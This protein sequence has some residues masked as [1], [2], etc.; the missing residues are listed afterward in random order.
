[1]STTTITHRDT[2]TVVQTAP[3]SLVTVN[4]GRVGPRGPAGIQ[5]PPGEVGAPGESGDAGP[6]GDP[7]PPGADGRTILSGS[8]APSSGLG[9]D[10]DFYLDTAASDLYGPKAGGAWGSGT[11]LVGPQ[12]EQGIQGAQGIQG[13]QG[14]Q[15][16]QGI[17]GPAGPNLTFAES[18][19]TFVAFIGGTNG[20][21]WTGAAIASGSV[22]AILG[23]TQSPG[24][25]RC[26]SSGSANS[27]YRFVTPAS[28]QGKSGLAFRILA[29]LY[30]NANTLHRFGYHDTT[31][32]AAPTDGVFFEVVNLTVTAKVRNNTSE[33]PAGASATL[34]NG[35][36]YVWDIDYTADDAVRFVIWELATGNKVYDQTVSGANVPNLTTRIFNHA[37]VST[38]SAG[39]SV[40]LMDLAYMGGGPA[41][42]NFCPVPA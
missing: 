22:S 8:G 30:T 13:E 24:A 9:E 21:P 5:G 42:P 17:Q 18:Q 20:F 32:Q 12:G 2:V 33:T 10:G 11:S 35:V 27:G 36:Y 31:T 4:V 14:A 34:S 7:G 25:A 15:G 19:W 6:Q 37:L 28:Y 1:M 29:L 38:N 41:R 3:P 26:S 40:S 16:A 39:G 23:P